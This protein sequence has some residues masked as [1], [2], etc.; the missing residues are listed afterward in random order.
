MYQIVDMWLMKELF[1]VSKK[2]EKA[3]HNYLPADNSE[4]TLYNDKH[5][6]LY[7]AAVLSKAIP[8][9]TLCPIAPTL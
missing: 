8:M 5:C 3:R 6:K 2:F 9:S 1:V 4:V 7:V